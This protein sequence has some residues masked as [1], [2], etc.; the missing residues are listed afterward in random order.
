MTSGRRAIRS[1][2]TSGCVMSA[3]T[4]CTTGAQLGAGMT[5]TH[6]ISEMICAP[7]DPSRTRRSASFRPTIPAAPM[8]RMRI[9]SAL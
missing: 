8:I 6:T 1:T 5:S 2:A 3:T 4:I 7:S 9:V